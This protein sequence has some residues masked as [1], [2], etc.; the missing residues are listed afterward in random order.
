MQTVEK[1][2]PVANSYKAKF[3]LNDTPL[4]TLVKNPKDAEDEYICREHIK[5]ARVVASLVFNKEFSKFCLETAKNNQGSITYD[6]IFK[7]FPQYKPLFAHTA[8]A[9]RFGMKDIASSANAVEDDYDF[10][11]NGFGYETEL[12]VANYDN[13]YLTDEFAV[14]PAIEIRDDMENDNHDI[15]FAWEIQSDG[16][17]VEVQIGEKDALNTTTPVLATTLKTMAE[18]G[19]GTARV[20]NSRPTESDRPNGNALETR[21]TTTCNIYGVQMNV[22]YE[23]HSGCNE[24]YASGHQYF[25]EPSS[26]RPSISGLAG[27]PVANNSR[28]NNFFVAYVTYGNTGVANLL[29]RIGALVINE[30][31]I[32]NY[33]NPTFIHRAYYNTFERDW[34]AREKALG[35]YRFPNNQLFGIR[36]RRVYQE[37]WF[38]FNPGA[39][40]GEDTRGTLSHLR[41]PDVRIPLL[42]IKNRGEFIEACDENKGEV[43]FKRKN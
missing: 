6:Q 3:P 8:I 28:D 36:G 9:K 1:E 5:I 21:A 32:I 13:P 40:V 18:L 14:S 10:V 31:T 30:K 19:G 16:S 12:L 2:I 43:E 33:G 4:E 17:L 22:H 24:I 15:I 38:T 35:T 7:Q 25:E 27:R 34:Y 29:T 39:G 20:V 23:N 11:H 42:T 37:E 26:G 41:T